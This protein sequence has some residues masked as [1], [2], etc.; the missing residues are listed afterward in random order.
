MVH[1][2]RGYIAVDHLGFHCLECFEEPPVVWRPFGASTHRSA[3]RINEG[4]LISEWFVGL[5]ESELDFSHA[6]FHL[7]GRVGGLLCEVIHK[8]VSLISVFWLDVF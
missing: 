8:I 7:L 6:P 5:G 1:L 3:A 4:T 2:C